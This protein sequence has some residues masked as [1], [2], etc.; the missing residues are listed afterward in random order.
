LKVLSQDIEIQ[1]FKPSDNVA[2]TKASVMGSTQVKRNT[3]GKGH[4][5]LSTDRSRQAKSG[6]SGG[7]RQIQSGGSRTKV[8]FRKKALQKIFS[9]W[10]STAGLDSFLRLITVSTNRKNEW[11]IAFAKSKMCS[12]RSLLWLTVR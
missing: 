10:A 4:V 1:M 11:L 12:K 2:V 5:N 6:T 8:S 7:N 9:A 3:K